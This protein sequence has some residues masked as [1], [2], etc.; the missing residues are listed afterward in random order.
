MS[1]RT[2]A[3]IENV[4][5]D[6]WR[7]HEDGIFVASSARALA[8][9]MSEAYNQY[10]EDLTPEEKSLRARQNMREFHES[11]G[12]HIDNAFVMR[13]QIDYSKPLGISNVDE[14]FQPGH[15]GEDA[16]V[17]EERADFIYTEN[18]K[19][20]LECRPADC[21]VLT[22][23]G[24]NAEGVPVLGLLHVGWQGLNAGYLE[25]AV[26]H[27]NE[28]LHVPTESLRIQMSGSGYAEN[29]H[30][31]NAEHPLDDASHNGDLPKRFTHPD[32]DHLFVN[33]EASDGV[34][35][36]GQPVWQFDI[37]M[38]GFIRK[39]L[40]DFG[41]D[42]YQL[43]EEGS[44][45]TSPDSGYS[46]HSRDSKDKTRNTRDVVVATMDTPDQDL[47]NARQSR[48]DGA[49]TIAAATRLLHE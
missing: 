12:L 42:D 7:L 34:G 32:R 14:L 1:E 41:I 24:V 3:T 26:S 2:V 36:N 21:P 46:S 6:N 31:K 20:I 11:I 5:R 17:A 4:Q 15:G 27:L 29:Y 9:N 43:Y 18:P 33:V 19:T 44:D 30:Y 49:A 39:K 22:I 10:G 23:K 40:K 25:S 28:N 16:T 8:N 47:I 37:D 13:P 48:I 38:P 45:T 35:D